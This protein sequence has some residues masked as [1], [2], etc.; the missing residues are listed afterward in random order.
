MVLGA[1]CLAGCGNSARLP[2][3][4]GTGPQPQLPP[5]NKSIIP[6][7]NVAPAR[8]WPEGSQPVTAQGTTVTAFATQLEHPRWIYVLPNGDVLVAETNAPPKPEDGKGIKGR[9]MKVF[10]K[11]AG[12]GTPSA[13]RIT[14][15]RDA[16]RDGRPETRT[17]FVEG[18]NSPFGMALVGNDFYVANSDAV[19]VFP[20]EPGATKL[21]GRGQIVVKL[22]AGP[23]NHHWTKNLIASPDGRKLYV[24]C[25][26]SG[27]VSVIDTD[28][29]VRRK[30][31]AVGKL[32]WGVAIR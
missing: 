29:A 1:A 22:P 24:A 2:V 28:R 6:T 31:I 25:G 26:R 11:K 12:A 21:Q 13:D 4:A 20:Y 32:P 19:V 5:P 27:T 9:L 17:V 15:L 3:E 23:I 8:G 7:L 16:D 10:Q 14:L 18:L 30:D